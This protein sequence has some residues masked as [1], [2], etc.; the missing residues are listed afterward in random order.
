MRFHRRGG[1]QVAIYFQTS[2]FSRALKTILALVREK[3]LERISD[4]CQ[5]ETYSIHPKRRVLS[6]RVRESKSKS[7]IESIPVEV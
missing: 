5:V 7:I 3:N 6:E 2:S 4:S 1:N